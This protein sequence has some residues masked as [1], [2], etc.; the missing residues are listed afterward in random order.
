MTLVPLGSRALDNRL[1]SAC[2]SFQCCRASLPQMGLWRKR[3]SITNIQHLM[4]PLLTSG[5]VATRHFT[6]PGRNTKRQPLRCVLGSMEVSCGRVVPISG[7]GVGVLATKDIHAGEIVASASPLLYF[8]GDDPK[9]SQVLQEQFEALPV[10][11]Q[12]A[13]FE[14]EDAFA[15]NTQEKT[16]VGIVRT[17]S[18]RRGRSMAQGV[19]CEELS[20][21]NHSC[22]PNCEHSWNEE[23]KI[24]NVYA[25]VDIPCG[26][27]LCIHYIDV[28]AI[29]LERIT[30][31][32]QYGFSCCC[33]ICEEPDASS[34]K[35]R[36][37][38]QKLVQITAQVGATEP[39]L[40]LDMV[41]EALRLYDDEGL[42][43]QSF[44][45]NAS[46]YAYQLA[47]Q[48]RDTELA[49]TWARMAYEHSI[50]CNGPNHPSSSALCAIVEQ[51]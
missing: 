36:L 6:A 47:L 13:V 11:Q 18:F 12:K 4:L 50:L 33:D 21:F 9:W 2:D 17:N 8:D 35:R 26:K 40:A 37:R 25:S 45:M 24:M 31:L 44:R 20:R 10:S 30:E 27:E 28:R 29:R 48:M 46:F 34:D 7:K 32:Q 19:L 14:L 51:L 38:M 1:V 42:A 5:L 22:S 43:I 3:D 41:A 49:R 23:T 16:L 15:A 39:L